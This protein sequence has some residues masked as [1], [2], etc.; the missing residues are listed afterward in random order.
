MKKIKKN[1][2]LVMVAYNEEDHI[3]RVIKEYYQ[4]I[5]LKLPKGSEFIIYLDSPTDNTSKIVKNL[6]KKIDIIVIEGKTN[7]GYAGAMTKA[8]KITKNNI[9]FYSDSS[10]KHQA[11]DFWKLIVYENKYDIITGLRISRTN[12]II[13]KVITLGQR[14]IISLLFF[15]PP[16]DFNTGYKIIHKNIIDNV[17]D[18]CKYMKQSFSSELLIRSYKKGYRLKNVPVVFTKRGKKGTGT[19]YQQLPK[20]I[21]KSLKGFILLRVELI[22]KLFKRR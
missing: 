18:E 4:E 16:Y 2:S 21:L 17:L 9:V 3:K 8:L 5:Y 10:G 19:N 11:K 1:I 14:A 15:I 13:R 22:L 7:L 6:A 12:P 20:I